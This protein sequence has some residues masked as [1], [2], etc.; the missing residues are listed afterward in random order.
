M[1]AFES[2]AKKY[3]FNMNILTFALITWVKLKNELNSTTFHKCWQKTLFCILN[4]NKVP[5]SG[6][7]WTVQ[8]G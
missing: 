8:G 6:L 4:L 3:A 5:A 1:L 2:K 7:K